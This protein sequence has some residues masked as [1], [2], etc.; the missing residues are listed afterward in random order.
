MTNTE[1]NELIEKIANL[2]D[3]YLE[4]TIDDLTNIDNM[5]QLEKKEARLQQ[6]L[7]NNL[8]EVNGGSK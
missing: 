3:K 2:L 1:E 5:V 7:Q 6:L 8:D 4:T